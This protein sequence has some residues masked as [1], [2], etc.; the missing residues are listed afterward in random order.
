VAD[1]PDEFVL[2]RFKDP[3]ERE[4][5]FNDPEVWPKVS[6]IF[7]KDSDQFVTNLLTQLAQLIERQFFDVF[8]LVHHFQETTHILFF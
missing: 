2:W 8:G 4:R 1:I 7:G 3:M 6:A 5:Q